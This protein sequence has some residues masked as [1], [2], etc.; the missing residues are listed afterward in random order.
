MTSV[1]KAL[2][3]GSAATALLLSACGSSDTAA[4][5]A[6]SS[7]AAAATS[8]GSS[9]AMTSEAMTSEAMT[10]GSAAGSSG[11]PAATDAAWCDTLKSQFAD[12]SGKSVSVYTSIVAPEDKPQIDS[13]KAFEACTGVKVNYEGSKEFETQLKVR[14][15]SANPP[16]IAFIP[17][18]G[19]LKTLVEETGAVKPAPKSV[20]DNVD[21][22]FGKDWKSYGTVNDIFFAAPLGANVKSFVWYSPKVFKEKGYTVPT[23]YKE[24]IALSDK[25]VADGKKPWCAGIESGVATGWTLTDW[26]ED[27]MLRVNGPDVYDQWISHKI[28]FNDPKVVAALEK[29]GE[30]VRNP[31][32]MNAGIGDVASIAATKFQDGGLGVA[33]GTCFL[34]RQASFYAANFPAGTKIAE[35]GDVFAFYLPAI[36]ED[37]GKPVEGGGEFVAAFSDRPEVQAFQTY[38]S[39]DTWAN[40]KAKATPGGGWVSANKGLDVANLTTPIDALS[41]KILQDP[42]T[43]FRFDASDLMPSAVGS[44][45]FFKGMTTWVRDNASSQSVL[46]TIEASWPAS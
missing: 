2:I 26:L 1:R 33:T 7:T 28:P 35:D 16:D 3:A 18:P 30:I 31:A 44:D 43:V 37:F 21:K 14:V 15:S 27:Y 25:I 19:L 12:I 34:H 46:D 6:A 45:S 17:Q 5:P 9:E 22:W 39:S 42:K 38:L 23:T 32:Y 36:S 4:T 24:L 41:A 40:E 20:A 11:A 29:V 10:D 8:A 13:Y